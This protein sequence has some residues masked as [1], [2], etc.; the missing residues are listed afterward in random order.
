MKL[1][2]FTTITYSMYISIDHFSI[3][4]SRGDPSMHQVFATQKPALT[5]IDGFGTITF[6]S[7]PD[8]GIKMDENFTGNCLI[9]PV[10]DI[11][12]T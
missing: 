4:Y 10:P 9:A 6:F 7:T 8:K 5:Y 12:P 11:L 3:S 2:I 1:H